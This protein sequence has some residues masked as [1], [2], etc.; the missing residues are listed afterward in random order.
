MRPLAEG[1]DEQRVVAA[2]GLGVLQGEVDDV[3]GELG[4]AALEARHDRLLDLELH[5]VLVAV[6]VGGAVHLGRGPPE[7]RDDGRHV[8]GLGDVVPV[9]VDLVGRDLGDHEA[10]TAHLGVA[11]QRV[12]VHLQRPLA[13]HGAVALV[14]EVVADRLVV[15]EAAQRRHVGLLH[16]EHHVVVEGLAV[17]LH[18]QVVRREA[19]AADPEPG[20]PDGVAEVVEQRPVEPLGDRDRVQVR[21]ER[22]LDRAALLGRQVPDAR[23]LGEHPDAV[24]DVGHPVE[25]LGAPDRAGR[26]PAPRARGRRCSPGAARSRRRPRCRRSGRPGAR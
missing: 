17:P 21:R 16:R 5:E 23:V 13:D 10:D 25:Q 6:L 9:Q 11:E 7:E 26:S 4:A 8:V 1:V 19:G 3:V 20:L 24:L 15:D 18:E 2:H 12:G 22:L 14:L